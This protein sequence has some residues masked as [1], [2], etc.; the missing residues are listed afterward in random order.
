MLFGQQRQSLASIS[1]QQHISF[2][3]TLPGACRG[4]SFTKAGNFFARARRA[5]IS[6]SPQ[7]NYLPDHLSSHFTLG[8]KEFTSGVN[9]MID[10]VITYTTDRAE[11]LEK[12]VISIKKTHIFYNSEGLKIGWGRIK[13][14]CNTWA[15]RVGCYSSAKKPPLCTPLDA[16]YFLFRSNFGQYTKRV[17]YVVQYEHMSK[18]FFCPQPRL[19]L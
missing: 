12:K 14:R 8:G 5:K 7:V 10:Q 18:V 3:M 9:E 11:N 2:C 1:E 4:F 13:V 6:L 15:G 16:S 17:L 19:L